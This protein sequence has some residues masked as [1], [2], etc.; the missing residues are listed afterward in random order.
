MHTLCMRKDSL[1][2]FY[3]F[4]TWK[5]L[6]YPA[7]FIVFCLVVLSFIYHVWIPHSWYVIGN[8]KH[9][10]FS[11][12]YWIDSRKLN[13]AG[14]QFSE[15]FHYKYFIVESFPPSGEMLNWA[16]CVHLKGSRRGSSKSTFEF[17]FTY[18]TKEK[19]KETKNK[20]KR[21][22]KKKNKNKRKIE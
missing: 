9:L 10:S 19:R 18:C 6:I 22:S 8:R 12:L 16:H 11:F 2:K 4:Y 14:S 17:F 3:E 1:E 7:S 15:L 5:T 13:P 20:N 21:K